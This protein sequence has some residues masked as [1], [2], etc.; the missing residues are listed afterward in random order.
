MIME[1]VT[2]IQAYHYAV[3]II[4]GIISALILIFG[5]L[6]SAENAGYVPDESAKLVSAFGILFRI[7][8][9]PAI[10][11]L[12][13]LILGW[14]QGVLPGIYKIEAVLF[15]F[16]AIV[17]ASFLVWRI[18]EELKAYNARIN[19][20]EKHAE[21]NKNG[22][23]FVWSNLWFPLAAMVLAIQVTYQI[24]NTQGIFGWAATALTV[25][26][27]LLGYVAMGIL[28]G[29]IEK[30]PKVVVKLINGKKIDGY[31]I[32]W[33]NECL[34]IVPKKGASMLIPRSQI[35]KVEYPYPKK[36]AV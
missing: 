1:V 28:Y 10:V 29:I 25:A 23:V 30:K 26:I 32:R 34:R 14:G 12:L 27:V 21:Y 33:E 18:R 7:F 35:A 36:K 5:R 13:L 20:Y 2:F 19:H 9:L 8:Q 22:I 4:G 17:A 24:K 6:M 31:L 3:L 16:G 11:F 15:N